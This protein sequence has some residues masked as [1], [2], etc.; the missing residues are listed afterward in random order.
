MRPALAAAMVCLALLTAGCSGGGD[1]PSGPSAPSTSSAAPSASVSMTG[2][3]T[4]S[5]QTASPAA[6]DLAG[7]GCSELLLIIQ[8]TDAEARQFVPASYTLL[9][10]GGQ[11]A[12]FI[13]LKECTDLT[14]D[15]VSVGNAS[16]SDVGVFIDKGE[17]GVFHYYQAWWTTDNAALWARLQ[18]QGWSGGVANDTLE[19]LGGSTGAG[20][21]RADVAYE[22][23]T[24]SIS[25]QVLAGP[26]SAENHAVGWFDTPNGTVTVDKVLHGAVLGTGSGTMTGD[27]DAGTLFGSPSRGTALW[28]EYAM[29]GRVGLP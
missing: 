23:A 22:R 3:P 11:T 26:A 27:G 29:D 19:T 12:G 21:A 16:T 20:E 6:F 4:G 24:Y 1:E 13:A 8:M 7:T 2:T 17:P 5:P 18:A 9:G 15:G 10:G 14:I 28:M 25:A